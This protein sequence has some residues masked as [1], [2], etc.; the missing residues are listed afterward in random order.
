MKQHK[1]SIIVE[2]PW[3]ALRRFT[4]ARIGLG[5]CGS[6]LPLGAHL[7]FKLAQAR[8]RDAVWVPLA[9]ETIVQQLEDRGITCLSLSSQVTDRAEFLARPDKGRTLTRESCERI[10]SHPDGCDLC[11]VISA[12]LSAP[13]IHVS[14]VDFVIAFHKLIGRTNLRLA[15][16][17]IVE[18]GRVAIAD[19]IGYL[20]RSRLSVILLGERPGL[21]SPDS[22]GAYLT[23]NPRPGTTDESRNCIS[24]IRKEGMPIEDGIRKLA[25]LI[26]SSLAAKTSGI[27]LKD[28]MSTTYLPFRGKAR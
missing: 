24:N 28:T 2:D 4:S 19:E 7:T 1:N 26:E 27:R 11:L 8:A 14:G 20:F 9:T 10:I 25:Y 16:L 6:S 21:S 18:N 22:L 3:S 5:R 15:P 12:G 23:Y 13:A 17:V